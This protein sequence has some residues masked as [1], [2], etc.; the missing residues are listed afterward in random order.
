MKQLLSPQL[1]I[2]CLEKLLKALE[3]VHNWVARMSESFSKP[4]GKAFKKSI[5]KA[6]VRNKRNI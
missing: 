4:N 1:W 6:F 2:C 5:K 3:T